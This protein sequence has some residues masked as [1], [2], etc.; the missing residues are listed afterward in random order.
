MMRTIIEIGGLL[1][2]QPGQLKFSLLR[3]AEEIS[4]YSVPVE[5]LEG[6]TVEQLPFPDQPN[7]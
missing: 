5:R 6:P 3:G 2:N 7:A 1:I 4:S